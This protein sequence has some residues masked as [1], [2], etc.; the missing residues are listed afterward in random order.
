M[1]EE[2]MQETE[3]KKIHIGKP[4]EM[5]DEWFS[6]KLKELE[7]ACNS[8]SDSIRELVSEVVP[9]YTYRK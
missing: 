7:E 1:G 4:I 6:G 2:G 9:T 5:D 3:N 8:E